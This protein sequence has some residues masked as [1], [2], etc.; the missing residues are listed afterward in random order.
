MPKRKREKDLHVLSEY[1]AGERK[2]ESLSK[3]QLA[4]RERIEAVYRMLL[5][6]QDQIAIVEKMETVFGV[7]RTQAY[8]DIQHTQFIFGS[9]K[10]ANKEFKRHMAEQMALK[11]FNIA[12]DKNDAKAMAS[13][14]RA[15]IEA[16][17]CNLNDPDIPDF[18]KL[19]PNIY[20]I[21]LHKKADALL[22]QLIAS[23]GSIDLSNMKNIEY[24]EFEEVPKEDDS[25]RDPEA[26][27]KE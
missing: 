11:T 19:K 26:P 20:P 8:R 23:P 3:H 5:E 25:N 16:T 4:K 1:Y 27:Q 18:E 13:A 22:D 17:G 15:Y 7:S 14:T 24:A 2:E 10:K 9:N 6:W 12:K 21:L